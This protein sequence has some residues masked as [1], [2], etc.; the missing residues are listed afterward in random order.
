VQC[1][2]TEVLPSKIFSKES[3]TKGG[4]EYFVNSQGIFSRI[5][6]EL[7][8]K[9]SAKSITHPRYD[10]V[11]FTAPEDGLFSLLLQYPSTGNEIIVKLYNSMG[12]YFDGFNDG[13]S[14]IEP[15]INHQSLE[16]SKGLIEQQIVFNV[17]KDR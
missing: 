11:E 8:I 6:S 7:H 9:K 12:F 16:S 2:E 1:K 13:T 14:N 15:L 4:Q 5:F 10:R 3:E 17:K